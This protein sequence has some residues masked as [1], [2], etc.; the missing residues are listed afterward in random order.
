MKPQIEQ[1]IQAAVDRRKAR[2]AAQQ[3]LDKGRSF[4]VIN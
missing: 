1:A 2:V 3:E 4:R